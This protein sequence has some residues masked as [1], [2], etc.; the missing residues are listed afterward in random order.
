MTKDR[1][2]PAEDDKLP[3][4]EAERQFNESLK[5]LVNMPHK[6]HVPNDG[7]TERSPQKTSKT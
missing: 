5:R 6:P 4:A 2:P 1:P 7:R 3:P